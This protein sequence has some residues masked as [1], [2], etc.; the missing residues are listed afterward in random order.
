MSSILFTIILLVGTFITFTNAWDVQLSVSRIDE[1]QM[2]KSVEIEF[3]TTSFRDDNENSKIEIISTDSEVIIPY[4]RYF[5][6]PKNDDRTT[7]N[8]KFNI[9]GLFLGYAKIYFQM[10]K[11]GK[12]IVQS[13]L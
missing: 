4:P 13:V 5:D 9:T 1:L 7:W 2:G 6:L 10:V 8:A 11:F 3:N 12:L